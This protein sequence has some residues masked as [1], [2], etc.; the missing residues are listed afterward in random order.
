MGP[1]RCTFNL[2]V[3]EKSGLTGVES[4][5]VCPNAAMI[6]SSPGSSILLSGRRIDSLP[7]RLVRRFQ[8]PSFVSGRGLGT[9]EKLHHCAGGFRILGIGAYSAAKADVAL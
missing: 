2:H 3:A 7:D 1:L 5:E 4:D 8:T 9:R 6:A